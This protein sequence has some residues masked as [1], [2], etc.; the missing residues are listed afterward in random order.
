ML[1]VP[2]EPIQAPADDDIESPPLGIRQQLIESGATV[3]RP[4][5][6]AINEL[7]GGPAPGLDVAPKLL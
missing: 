2:S 7:H 4:T 6:P 5:H 3:L 1:E